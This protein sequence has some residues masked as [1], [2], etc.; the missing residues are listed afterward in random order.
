MKNIG[1]RLTGNLP[2]RS[3]K[4]LLYDTSIGRRGLVPESCMKIN[5]KF[6]E[7]LKTK[8]SDT[9]KIQVVIIIQV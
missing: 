2:L 8:A 7:Y 1:R 4:T 5:D 6:E 3:I 9:C